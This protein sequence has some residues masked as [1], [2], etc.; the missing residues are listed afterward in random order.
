LP[1]DPDVHSQLLLV[2]VVDQQ[3]IRNNKTIFDNDKLSI[4]RL[5]SACDSQ[6]KSVTRE[7]DKVGNRE[8]YERGIYVSHACIFRRNQSD[9]GI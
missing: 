3:A 7:N 8:K 6:K 1:D 5:Q 4:L 2:I 9:V